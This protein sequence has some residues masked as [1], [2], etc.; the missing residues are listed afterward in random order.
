VIAPVV[1]FQ[2]VAHWSPQTI[3]W[4]GAGLIVAATLILV[5]EIKFGGRA[6]KAA[7]LVEE[8]SE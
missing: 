3:S 1:A 7:A 4:L 8:V 6:R 2:L 5:P